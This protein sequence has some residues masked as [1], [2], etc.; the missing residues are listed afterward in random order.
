M[1]M[2]KFHVYEAGEPWEGNYHEE[3][4]VTLTEHSPED[5]DNLRERVKK[6][7]QEWFDNTNVV[8]DSEWRGSK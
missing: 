8:H 2:M 4:I 3:V 5:E 7:I 6:S 1:L